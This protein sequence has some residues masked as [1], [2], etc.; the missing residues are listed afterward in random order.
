MTYLRRRASQLFPASVGFLAGMAV[1]AV[2]VMLFRASEPEMTP[3]APPSDAAA[4]AAVP[5]AATVRPRARAPVIEARPSANDTAP[6]L[7][8]D[9]SPAAVAGS[10]ERAV[11]ELRQR[12]FEVPVLGAKREDLLST[13]DQARGQRRHEALDLLAPRNTPVVAVEDGTVA[14]LF[15]S[16]AGGIT[17][18]QFDPTSRYAYYYAHLERYAD[19]LSEGD[20]VTRGQVLGYVGTTGNAPANTPHLHFA[21]FELTAEKRWWQGTPLDPFAV[22]R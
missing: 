12:R 6:S 18:Y 11:E 2:L 16:Q 4:P 10:A 22:L 17:V 8:S 19:G 3:E 13:F 9:A 5:P 21:I 1:M 20:T 15:N 7:P 14:K